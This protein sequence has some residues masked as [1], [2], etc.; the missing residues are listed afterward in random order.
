MA[1]KVELLEKEVNR[2]RLLS[3]EEIRRVLSLG[4]MLPEND[5]TAILD[6]FEE[7]QPD[8]YQAILGEL[9]SAIEE[10]NKEMANLFLD[11][12]FDIIW[13]YRKSFGQPP[14]TSKGDDWV[15]N[16]L[17]LLNS[18]LKALLDDTP[19]HGKIKAH[20]QKRFIR[21][22]VETGIQTELLEILT[23][24]VIKYAEF[25]KRRRRAIHSTQ[26]FLFVILRLMDELY[27]RKEQ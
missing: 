11:L 21:R 15:P 1:D 19:M 13:V 23:E 20:L 22:C 2:M 5:G 7:A 3:K 16:S 27:S 25:K 9:S 6:E 26:C 17:T 10:D 14:R 18:E 4:K 8:I 24:E 12:C